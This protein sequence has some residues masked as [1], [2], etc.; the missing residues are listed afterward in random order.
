M[1]KCLNATLVFTVA[2]ETKKLQLNKNSSKF[3]V[4]MLMPVPLNFKTDNN[5]YTY[6]HENQV[7]MFMNALLYIQ[8]AKY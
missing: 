8:Q 7:S 6:D 3:D 5:S 2:L 4:K 1:R